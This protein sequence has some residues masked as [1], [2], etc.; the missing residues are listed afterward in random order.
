MEQG[1]GNDT[2]HATTKETM[3]GTEEDETGTI[4]MAHHPQNYTREEL[5]ALRNSPL[6]KAPTKDVLQGGMPWVLQGSQN[7]PP[8]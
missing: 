6:V 7:D 4:A 8:W 5:L 2:T 3:A 1:Q